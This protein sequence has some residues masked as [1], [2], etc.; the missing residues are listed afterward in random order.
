LTPDLTTK[1][2]KKRYAAPD[3]LQRIFV[4]FKELFGK[5]ASAIGTIIVLMFL[6]LALFGRFIAPYGENEQI[7]TDLSQPP[8]TTHLMGT[9]HLGRDIFS[10]VILGA[11]DVLLLAGVGTLLAVLFGTALGLLSG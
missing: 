6:F 9:D 4:I 5:K 7:Y 10:R 1:V 11:R 3:W 8:S 2:G